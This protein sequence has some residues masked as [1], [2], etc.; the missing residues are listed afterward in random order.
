MVSILERVT[1]R[2]RGVNPCAMLARRVALFDHSRP[3]RD[4]CVLSRER[5]PRAESPIQN[6]RV[7]DQRTRDERPTERAE[8]RARCAE[9][10]LESANSRRF[11]VS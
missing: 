5:R 9:V 8:A 2:E 11:E 4:Q 7:I 10:C 3:Y 6:M 1:W